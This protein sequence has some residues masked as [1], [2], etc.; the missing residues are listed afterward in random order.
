MEGGIQRLQQQLQKATGPWDGDSDSETLG[1]GLLIYKTK[2][3]DQL[4]SALAAYSNCLQSFKMYLRSVKPE[5]LSGS[6]SV[7]NPHMV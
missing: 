6:Q 7:E 3:L 5:S 1:V 4:F 2:G